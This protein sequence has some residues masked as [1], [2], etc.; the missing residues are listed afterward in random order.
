MNSNKTKY[1]C[2]KCD[3]V[4]EAIWYTFYELYKGKF[5]VC[6]ECEAKLET[7]LDFKLAA[8]LSDVYLVLSLVVTILLVA[9]SLYWSYE[10]AGKYV[11]Y[12]GIAVGLPIILFDDYIVRKPELYP[13]IKKNSGVA[14]RK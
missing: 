3:S 11:L 4:F 5:I 7:D 8:K 1:R 10:S 13:R 14:L 9:T 2:A 12:I 6:P